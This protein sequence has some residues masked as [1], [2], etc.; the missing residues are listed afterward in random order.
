MKLLSR[1]CEVSGL[2]GLTGSRSSW[3]RGRENFRLGLL[4]P[5]RARRGEVVKLP[6]RQCEV[7][8]LLGLFGAAR[9]DEERS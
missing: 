4:S 5:V 9:L 3:M 6:S 8:G 2:L 1:R 7:A